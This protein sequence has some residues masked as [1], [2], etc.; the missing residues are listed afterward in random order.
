MQMHDGAAVRS[1]I[2]LGRLCLIGKRRH[3]H[4]GLAGDC[5]GLKVLLSDSDDL[6][7]AVP[8]NKRDHAAHCVFSASSAG[9][10]SH[11]IPIVTDKSPKRLLDVRAA[12]EESADLVHIPSRKITL[13]TRVSIQ[14]EV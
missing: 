12:H 2:W 13:T 9:L 11:V 3:A 5:H 4:R 14:V 7:L 6:P 8:A 1:S 10:R